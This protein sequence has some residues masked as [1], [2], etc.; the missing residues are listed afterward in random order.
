MERTR[1][2]NRRKKRRIQLIVLG[3]V[4]AALTVLL[5]VLLLLPKETR[6]SA[7]AK[8]AGAS[9]QEDAD[10]TEGALPERNDAEEAQEQLQKNADA[11]MFR[12]LLNTKPQFENGD[13]EGDLMIK[14]APENRA[15]VQVEIVLDDS[16]ETAYK[17][18]VLRPGEDEFYG[19]LAV[20]LSKGV[21]PATAHI[22]A[23]DAGTGQTVAQIDSEMVI[24]VG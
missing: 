18:A 6:T 23:L 8:L 19:K 2:R 21:Y 1:K 7:G 22:Y 15:D 13:A 9:I 5:V 16:G 12:I 10:A 3:C 20:K 14:N 4:A 24:T 17:T 11:S